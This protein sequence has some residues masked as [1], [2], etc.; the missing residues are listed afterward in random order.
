MTPSVLQFN[1]TGLTSGHKYTVQSVLVDICK[2][3][4]TARTVNIWNSLPDD[5]IDVNT[6]QTFEAGLDKFWAHQPIIFD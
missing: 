4:F 3:S 2:Y 6:V 1:M 5:V